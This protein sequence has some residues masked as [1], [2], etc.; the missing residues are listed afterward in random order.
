MAILI[1][2]EDGEWLTITSE[3]YYN[4]SE[5][6]AQYLTVKMGEKDYSVDSFTM[7]S[8]AST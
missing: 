2:F 1:G 7:S 5:K 4:A 6:G 8:T 3:G